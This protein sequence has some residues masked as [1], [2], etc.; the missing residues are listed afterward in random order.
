MQPKTF[1]LALVVILGAL[2]TQVAAAN[3]DS[4]GFTEWSQRAHFGAPLRGARR[5][6]RGSPSQ[7][8]RSLSWCVHRW[9]RA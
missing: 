4:E 2:S 6:G 7:P 1:V 9:M 8:W 5:V 3:E